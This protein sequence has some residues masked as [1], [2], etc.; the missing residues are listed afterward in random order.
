MKNHLRTLAISIL[1]LGMLACQPKD[2]LNLDGIEVN[3]QLSRFDS[4]LMQTPPER[5]SS[6]WNS[7]L[8]ELD[9][10]PRLFCQHIIDNRNLNDS[11][12]VELLQRFRTD[13]MIQHVGQLTH[14]TFPSA[15]PIRQELYSAFRRYKYFFPEHTVPNIITFISGFNLS[16]GIDSTYIYIGLDRFLGPYIKYYSM[17]GIP[18]YMQYNMR[19]DQIAPKA[20]QAWLMNDFPRHDSV[21]NLLSH[22]LWQAEIL[23]LTRRLMPELPD[24]TLFGFTQDQ[25]RFCTNNEEM[26]WTM[27]IEQKLLFSTNQFDISKFT[28]DGPFTSSFSAEAPAKAAVWIGY[29][30]IQQYMHNNSEVTPAN[31]MQEDDYQQILEASRYNP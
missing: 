2:E 30:I 4:I 3:L 26:M 9:S 19:P 6:S 1:S 13:T 24:T 31:L 12:C 25:L 28:H 23:Y 5:I 29:N 7:M 15:E 8:H 18:K 27:L 11:Q 14:S 17:L 10:F 20:I 16:I 22:M 21:N